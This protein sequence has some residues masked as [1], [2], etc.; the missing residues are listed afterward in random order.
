MSSNTSHQNEAAVA[1]PSARSAQSSRAA[2]RTRHLQLSPL[3][4]G[5]LTPQSPSPSQSRAA[6]PLRFFG[7]NLHRAHSRDEPFIPVD[8]FQLRFRFFASPSS[9]PQRHSVDLFDVDCSNTCTTCLPLPT[10]CVP[11]SKFRFRS[12]GHGMQHFFV[13][14]LPRQVY[15]HC[16]F[17]LPALYFTRVS[18]IFE[19]AEV[20]KHEVQRMIEACA[21]ANGQDGIA[22]GIAANIGVSA[23]LGT[24]RNRPGGTVFPFPEDWNPPSVSP[25]LSRFKHS[26]E[27]FVDSL[28]REWKTLN[29]V[30]VLLC[31]YVS[32]ADVRP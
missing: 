31:T 2:S 19:D 5:A 13:D 8:P 23:S 25:A 16:L 7:W 24:A 4:D 12:C 9:T 32:I 3:K 1:S 18:R 20:S 17:R 21:P 30:S 26:W 14:T 10:T 6:S 28:L 15:L 29:L 22:A 27:S 11:G